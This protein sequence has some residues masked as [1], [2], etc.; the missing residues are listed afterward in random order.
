MDAQQ[1]RD[2][3]A[4]YVVGTYRRQPR[5]FV[6]GEGVWI[7]DAEG[8]RY[9]DF[10]A[11]I[12][13]NQLGHAHP[14]MV[15]TI[16][17]QASTLIHTSNNLLTEPQARLAEKLHQVTGADKAFF[18]NCGTTAVESALKIAKKRG[19]PN[20]TEFVAL[21]RSFHGRTLGALSATMQPKYQDPFRPL[22]PGFRSV[23]AND[24]DSLRAA[25]NDETAAIIL[26]PIQG[27]GGLTTLSVEFL[28]A[29][30]EVATSAGALLIVDEVQTGMG[31]TG[32]WLALHRS[33]ITPDLVTIAKGL[34]SGVPIGACLTY[35]EASDVLQPGD[36][37]STYGGNALVCAVALTVLETIEREGLLENARVRGEQLAAGL[38]AIGSPIVDVRGHGLMRGAVLDRPI[39]RDLVRWGLDQGIILNATD[40]STLRFVPPLIVDETHVDYALERVE[41]G[42]KELVTA[43]A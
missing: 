29:A 3:D 4:K 6:R 11:G 25:V 23:P 15:D 37:G 40:D 5:V 12:A 22:V 17:R 39:A 13:V 14:A 20:R 33:G 43:A 28:Q 31:R 8:N 2:L 41:R 36:H 30:R 9:L 35:G 7:W 26:E 42:L 19:Q 1:I 34:G 38:R 10:L 24:A 18:V 27:E 32:H 16:T 21:D